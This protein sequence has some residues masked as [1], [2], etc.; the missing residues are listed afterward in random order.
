MTDVHHVFDGDLGRQRVM[1]DTREPTPIGGGALA[2]NIIYFARALREAGIP[3]GPGAVLDA[4]AAVEAAGI[5]QPADFYATLHA[6]FVK[7]HEHSLLFDQAFAIFWKR[8]GLLEKLIAMMSPQARRQRTPKSAE[9]G[10]SRVAD[11]LFKSK[12]GRAERPPR[13]SISTRASPCRTRKS[14]APRTSP[15]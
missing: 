12:P 13:R 9:A 6:V 4:L 5:R 3:L 1:N 15:R 8:R 2:E 7:K 14:C 11:A 10:A